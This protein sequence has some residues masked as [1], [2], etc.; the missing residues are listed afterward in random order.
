M[1]NAMILSLIQFISR[2]SDDEVPRALSYGVYISQL[3][4]FARVASHLADFNARN[5]TLTAKLP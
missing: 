3:Y 1:T 2:F 4:R 5:K